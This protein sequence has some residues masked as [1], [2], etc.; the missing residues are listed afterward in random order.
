MIRVY[1]KLHYL[2]S[3]L[4]GTETDETLLT[5]WNDYDG[6][7]TGDN[8]F[9]N[10]KTTY[11]TT[12]NWVQLLGMEN[13]FIAPSTNFAKQYGLGYTN[14]TTI[15]WTGLGSTSYPGDWSLPGHWS[16]GVPTANDDV[17]IPASLPIGSCGY[18]DVDLIAI[19]HDAHVKTLKIESGASLDA[20]N[21]DITVYGDENAW[22]NN[23]TFIGGS[24]SVIFANG[25]QTKNVE[26]S[27]NNQFHNLVI[28]DKTNLQPKSGSTSTI[29]GNIV[30]DGAILSTNANTFIFNGNIEEQTISGI[31]D[32]NFY[33]LTMNNSHS[34]GK[35]T[36]NTP[37]SVSNELVLANN[38]I[39][40]NSTNILSMEAGSS[41]SPEGGSVD[42][43]VSGPI[44]KSGTTAF[45]F[46]IGE[47]AVWAPIGIA[48][49][50]TE[51]TITA[52][53]KLTNGPYNWSTAYMCSGSEML[54]TSGVENWVLNTTD[55]HPAVTLYWK[56]TGS[57]IQDPADLVVAHY[58]GTCW[59]NMGGIAV[60]DA[61]SGFITSNVEL[62]LTANNFGT[63]TKDNTLPIE[64]SKFYGICDNESIKISWIT[65]SEKDN[66]YFTIE[67]SSDTKNWFELKE[68]YGAGNSNITNYYAYNDKN[69]N[70]NNYYRL[71]QT[72]LDGT[73]SY[74]EIINV[75]GCNS[76][77]NG[78]LEI[79]PNPTNGELNI[80]CES[81][82][83]E[84]KIID[85][86]G[87]LM[88]SNLSDG[89]YTVQLDLSKFNKGIY[90]VEIT[91]TQKKFNQRVN[92]M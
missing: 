40:T 78:R 2:D 43:Y 8:T 74:T 59:E 83:I 3:E 61:S 15:T 82:I 65:M 4:T 35:L 25:D 22:I 39:I 62:H 28:T 19:F 33:N 34:L 5:F 71:K 51:S 79:Y 53:Y 67:K 92:I 17:L 38:I 16:G 72:D 32:L 70:A 24:N 60:G 48:A 7:T 73:F 57:G 89:V 23:G 64:I 21:F 54:Y 81:E 56:T 37:I 36:L 46:P 12:E 18:P 66:S 30:C 29:K 76:M 90:V 31:G 87:K 6:L 52:E 26:V 9:V 69:V 68:V 88:Y 80:I 50:A 85:L 47:D 55:A 75:I 1:T 49:P 45:V 13:N 58:N 14:V 84:V 11:N 42:S 86:T 10:G 91:T 44:N 27:G 77:L 41:V 63:K 20:S